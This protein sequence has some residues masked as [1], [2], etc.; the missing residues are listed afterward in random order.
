MV[1]FFQAEDGIRDALV[2]GV[3][4]CALPISVLKQYSLPVMEYSLLMLLAIIGVACVAC[5]YVPLRLL[6]GR[7]R[8]VPAGS[9]R[10]GAFFSGTGLGSPAV[11]MG[12]LR[13]FRPFLWHSNVS[14]S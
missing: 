5:V 3:Q 11:G 7:S 12:L 8:K 1:F 13:K 4:R 2:T 6:E 10:Y 9:F 14:L